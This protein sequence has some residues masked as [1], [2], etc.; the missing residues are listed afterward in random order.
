[1]GVSE[2]LRGV[3]SVV[4][5]VATVWG[6]GAGATR[7]RS[8]CGN[9][10]G[11]AGLQQLTAAYSAYPTLCKQA[12]LYCIPWTQNWSPNTK[13]GVQAAKIVCNG[14][15]LNTERAR[16]EGRSVDPASPS[17]ISVDDTATPWS[18]GSVVVTQGLRGALQ[19]NGKEGRLLKLLPEEHRWVVQLVGEEQPFKIKEENL[20][21]SPRERQAAFKESWADESTKEEKALQIAD[22]E[23]KDE[24]HVNKKHHEVL[25]VTALA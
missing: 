15:A 19:H 17:T 25:Q 21:L 22:D 23:V 13:D 1:M 12:T 10:G 3:G 8:R 4:L 18:A 5:C 6:K 2:R 20:A 11:S 7:P 9:G 24:K 14:L 16:L